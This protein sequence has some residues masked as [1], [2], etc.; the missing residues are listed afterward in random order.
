MRGYIIAVLIVIVLS[1]IIVPFVEI[2]EIYREKII[3]SSAIINACA[4]SKTTSIR[5]FNISNLDA[6]I[7]EDMLIEKFVES[8]EEAMNL[9]LKNNRGNIF[10]FESL[11]N[12]YNDI[13]V[14]IEI[15][16]KELEINRGVDGDF[17][18]SQ[19]TEIRV[20]AET[21]YKYKTKYLKLAER[22]SSTLT[23]HDFTVEKVYLISIRN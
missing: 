23:N 11:D 20:K 19:I 5:D 17:E 13:R 14:Y 9:R 1:L 10:T 15:N 16:Q 6:I 4:A 2:V 12:K 21:K 18:D 3:I 8:F 22:A 7:D